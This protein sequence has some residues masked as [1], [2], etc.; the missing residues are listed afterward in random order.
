MSIYDIAMLI[1]FFGAVLFG[2]RKGLA[3]Q[4]A[5]LAAIVLSYFVAVNFRGPVASLISATEPWNQFAAMLIL[6]LG[7]SLVVWTA[8]ASLSQSIKKMEMKGFDRQAGAILGAVKGAILCMLATVFAVSLFASTRNM[9]HNSALGH[10]VVSGVQQFSRFTPDE[11]AQ[12]LDPH[13]EKFHQNIGGVPEKKP[14]FNNMATG[15]NNGNGGFQNQP[16]A[17]IGFP[18][19][20]TP[21]NG[22]SY[23]GGFNGGNF[24]NGNFQNANQPSGY[25]SPVRSNGQQPFSNAATPYPQN[26]NGGTTYPV[27]PAN[28]NYQNGNGGNASNGFYNAGF[29]NNANTSRDQFNTNQPPVNS[30]GL[31][32][33]DRNFWQGNPNGAGGN[34]QQQPQSRVTTGANGWPEINTTINTRDLLQR[35]ASTTA[36]MLRRAY[37]SSNQ[38]R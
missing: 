33:G 20:Q 35:G 30:G 38:P 3:W 28:P 2:F 24:Q 21:A 34:L 12:F 25:Q 11:L 29:D 15:E 19:N 23:D 14:F 32:N 10:Y 16:V 27:N 18:Q 37:E 5:S 4:V 9:V 17:P 8:Y 6:F 7:T 13:F 31:A 22:G 1:I 26:R 36:D